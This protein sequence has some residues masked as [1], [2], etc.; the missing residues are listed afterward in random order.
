[1]IV[2]YHFLGKMF[3]WLPGVLG[4]LIS[5]PVDQVM[6]SPI[7]ESGVLYFLYL[8]SGFLCVFVDFDGSGLFGVFRCGF[9]QRYVE[10]WVYLHLLGQQ[11]FECDWAKF[12]FNLEWSQLGVVQFVAWSFCFDISSE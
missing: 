6:W 1:M 10:Y 7:H 3:F 4:V 11:Q 9:Q 2:G 5:F 12:L 8:V